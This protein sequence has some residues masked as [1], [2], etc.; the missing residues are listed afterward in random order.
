[1][2]SLP[3]TVLSA[4]L[5]AGCGLLDGAAEGNREVRQGARAVPVAYEPSRAFRGY[6]RAPRVPRPATEYRRPEPSYAAERSPLEILGCVLG[7]AFGGLHVDRVES[8]ESPNG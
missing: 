5:L 4:L 1:M 7:A 6:G 8:P 2:K 3:A